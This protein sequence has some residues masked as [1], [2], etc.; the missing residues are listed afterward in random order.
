MNTD[1]MINRHDDLFA[2][3]IYCSDQ[4]QV[5][6]PACFTTLERICINQERGALLSQLNKET[7]QSDVRFYECPPKLESKIR[8]ITQKVIDN[9]L[10]TN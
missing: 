6:K 10:I 7:P 8:F 3:L 5:G 2:V 9:H 1:K 4:Q